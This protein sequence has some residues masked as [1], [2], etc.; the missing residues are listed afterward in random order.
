M[1]ITKSTNKEIWNRLVN[2]IV[3]QLEQIR[4]DI[5]TTIKEEFDET[6]YDQWKFEKEKDEKFIKSAVEGLINTL[7]VFKTKS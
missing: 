1:T 6:T 5:D 7:K 2:K 3:P 4:E